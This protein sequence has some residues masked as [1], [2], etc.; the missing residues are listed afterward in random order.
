MSHKRVSI[1]DV[2]KYAGVSRSTVSLVLQKSPLVADNTRVLVENAIEKTGYV[3][4]R[5]AANLRLSKSHM[6]GWIV[7]DIKNPFYNQMLKGV[8]DVLNRA[9][10]NL[11]IGSASESLEKQKQMMS[12]MVEQRMDALLITPIAGST[13]DMFQWLG[14]IHFPFVFAS[15]FVVGMNADYVGVDNFEGTRKATQHLIDIGHRTIA[16]INYNKDTSITHE[17]L[18]GFYQALHDSGLESVPRLMEKCGLSFDDG[19]AAAF[20]LMQAE[21]PPTAIVCY[22][23][24]V[25]CGVLVGLTAQGISVGKDGVAV[26]GA[27]D[28]DIANYWTPRITTTTSLPYETGVQAAKLV[29]KR[30]ENREESPR[31]ILMIP[32]LIIRQ[33]TTGTSPRSSDD[34]VQENEN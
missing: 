8:E 6:I 26:V 15:R 29:L 13:E 10:Y 21:T 23:D 22:N 11:F 25:A 4:N 3:Y 24:T 32:E 33:S 9:Q 17:R 30:I 1:T 34:Q 5:N 14:Q 19:Y 27:D 18:Q 2:A 31:T 7:P 12:V 20:R 16:F 28:L